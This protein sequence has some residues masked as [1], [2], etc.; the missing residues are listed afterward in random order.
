MIKNLKKLKINLF[1][2]DFVTS[3]PLHPT[4]KKMRGYNQATLLALPIANYFKIPFK[5]DIIYSERDHKSQ[6]TLSFAERQKNIKNSFAAKI[7]LEG[8]KI[9]LVDD[10]FTS[11]ATINAC[12]GILKEKGASK[13]LVL[14][15]A[16]AKAQ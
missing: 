15:L 14:V 7:N 2:Y 3:V 8:K 11:G 13:I 1:D 4:K 5:N 9:I 16:L 10:I 12:S 6:T